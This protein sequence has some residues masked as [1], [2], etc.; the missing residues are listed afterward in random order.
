[1]TVA[2]HEQIISL[3]A[4]LVAGGWPVRGT[5]VEEQHLAALVPPALVK[6]FAPDEHQIVLFPPPFVTVA[7]DAEQNPD[8]WRDFG[9]MSQLHPE[10]AVLIADFG[11]GS[12]TSVVVDLHAAPAR[13][14][15]LAWAADGNRWV[16]IAPSVEAF[17][18]L[19]GFMPA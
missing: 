15:R 10:D 17:L 14:M 18:P 3:E 5:R 13:V 11:L 6:R 1:M 9:A 12:D 7:E 2:S 8:Y 4:Q 19:L 16:E